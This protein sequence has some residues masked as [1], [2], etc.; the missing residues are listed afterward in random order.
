MHSSD[1]KQEKEAESFIRSVFSQFLTE[2]RWLGSRSYGSGHIHDTYLVETDG[3]NDDYI[4]Q[5]VNNAVFR[6][7]PGMQE[8][9]EL[10]TGHIRKKLLAKKDADVKRECLTVIPAK[11]GK[12]WILDSDGKYWRLF[13]F[14]PDHRSY[15]LVD[16]PEKAYEGGRAVGKFQSML[17]DLD[18]NHLI[19]TIPSFN[20]IETKLDIFNRKV[21]EDPLSRVKK[22]NEEI[23]FVTDR[24]DGLRDFINHRRA[25]R[26]PTR[27]THNDTKFNNILF[28]RDDKSLCLI[29]LDTVMPGYV[30][31]DF[32]DAIRTGACPASEDEQDLS[33]ISMDINLFRAYSAGYLSEISDTL[34]SI[35]KEYLA[36]AP[37][38]ITY[39]QVVRFLADYIDGDKYYKIHYEEHNLQRTRSQIALVKSMEEQ[40]P[41]MQKI[42][43]ELG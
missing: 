14:I 12:S 35:E 34:N 15:D 2:G 6:D 8:N 31:Y 19:E 41:E 25:G 23:K 7:V 30:H 33:R 28:D 16:S 39:N 36:F 27:I 29:D 1:I 42:I 24:L 10:V 38:L 22:L 20:N 5:R 11:T 40:Y 4:L 13:L 21:A 3:D 17:R 37:Q 9:I 32:G 43:G 18:G 26:I